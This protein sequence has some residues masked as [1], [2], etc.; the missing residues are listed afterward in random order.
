M[1]IQ[2]AVAGLFV[3]I[4]FGF[5]LGVS[6]L[7]NPEKVLAFLN[8]ARNWDPSLLLVIGAATVTTFFGYRWAT[9]KKPLFE[10]RHYL[11]TAKDIDFRLITG[12]GIFGVGW[13]LAGY[14]PGPAIAGMGSGSIEPFIFIVAMIVGS[15]L[16]RIYQPTYY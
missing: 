11:P 8:V 1:N 2:R 6:Q 12:A 10:E 16:A 9:H 15:Q 7:A 13:G 4:L 14:C 5:G 3:G